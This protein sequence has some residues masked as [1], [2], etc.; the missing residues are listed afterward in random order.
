MNLKHL[1]ILVSGRVQGVW[2]RASTQLKAREFG[3]SGFVKNVAD[4]NVYIEVEG[5]GDNLTRF[6]EWCKKGPELARVD[7][8]NIQEDELKNFQSF[9][10]IR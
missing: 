2:F 7:Q 4:G 6:V 10:I 3:L 9:E 1:N 5:T 8:V